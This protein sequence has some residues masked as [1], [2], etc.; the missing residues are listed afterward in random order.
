MWPVIVSVPFLRALG[1]ARVVCARGEEGAGE[2]AQP[3][4]LWAWRAQLLS[5]SRTCPL[6]CLGR[7][8]SGE[9]AAPR[10][11]GQGGRPRSHFTAVVIVAELLAALG[12]GV[13][14]ATVAVF[15]TDDF[16]GARTL[17]TI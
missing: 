14:L 3:G 15:E 5:G 6:F 17:T 2:R 10:R 12:S 4:R 8:C 16:R 1:G 11:T 9:K 7:C 13:V